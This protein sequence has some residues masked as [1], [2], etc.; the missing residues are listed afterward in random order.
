M[1]WNNNIGKPQWNG[2]SVNTVKSKN[3]VVS[4]ITTDDI[5]AN[6]ISTGYLFAHSL[7]TNNGAISFLSNLVLN[8]GVIAL[9]VT[10]TFLTANAGILYVNGDAVAFPS[11]LSTIADWSQFSAV[12]DVNMSRSSLYNVQSISTNILSTGTLNTRSISTT[13]L[14]SGNIVTNNISSGNIFFDTLNGRAG[15]INTLSGNNMVYSNAILSNVNSITTFTRSLNA[16]TIIASNSITSFA[17][18]SVIVSTGY[19]VADV[20]FFNST[21]NS[22][23]FSYKGIFQSTATGVLIASNISTGFIVGSNALFS[24]LNT[25]N[26][27]TNSISTNSIS[28]LNLSNTNL[29]TKNVVL[30][31]GLL[32]FDWNPAIIYNTN[33]NVI[34]S[35][36]LYRAVRFNLGVSPTSNITNWVANAPYLQYNCAFVSGVGSFICLVNTPGSPTSPQFQF[37]V[38]GQISSNASPTAVWTLLETD[39]VSGITGDDYSFIDVGTGNFNTIN[40]SSIN[41]SGSNTNVTISSINTNN[42]SSGTANINFL[43]TSNIYNSNALQTNSLD[44]ISDSQ[45]NT[46]TTSGVVNTDNILNVN[47]LLALRSDLYGQTNDITLDVPPFTTTPQYLKDILNIREGQFETLNIFGG[48]TGNTI[49]PPYRNNSIVNIG[50]S[51]ISPGIVTIGG[52]NAELTTALT[53]NGI[54]SLNGDTTINGLNTVNG[55]TDL[56]GDLT[57]IGLTTITGDTDITGLTS[58]TGNTDIN[59]ACEVTGFTNLLG[60]LSVEAGIAVAGA[61]TFQ[62]GDI[63]IGSSPG[64][65]VVNNFNLY[66]YYNGTDIQNLTVNGSGDFRQNVNID[67]TLTANILNLNS[68]TTKYAN[69]STLLVSSLVGFRGSFNSLSTNSLSTGVILANRGL[70]NS[71]STNS[72]STGVILADRGLFNSLSTNYISSGIITTQ[73][74]STV[75]ISADV[76]NFKE[77]FGQELNFKRDDGGNAGIA[78]YRDIDGIQEVDS[79][80]FINNTDG[81]TILSASTITLL[82][83]KEINI[84]TLKN[85]NLNTPDGYTYAQ[86][87]STGSLY[88]STINFDVGVGQGLLL[89]ARPEEAVGLLFY[90]NIDGVQEIDT[91]LGLDNENNF[92]LTSFSSITI[93]AVNNLAIATSEQ[94][95]LIAQSNI[96]IGTPHVDILYNANISTINT[97]Q[98]STNAVYSDFLVAYNAVVASSTITRSLVSEFVSTGGLIADRATIVNDL[99]ANNLFTTNLLTFYI[100]NPLP[101][102]S[103][104]GFNDNLNIAGNDIYNTFT[105][106]ASNISTNFIS[107]GSLFVNNSVENSISSLRTSTGALFAG[108][109]SSLQVNTSSITGNRALLDRIVPFRDTGTTTANLYPQSAGSQIGFGFTTAGGGFYGFGTFRSTITQVIQPALDAGAFSNVVRINGFVSTQQI[110][111]SSIF[112]RANVS[113]QLLQSSNIITSNIQTQNITGAGGTLITLGTGLQPSS[114]NISLG[115]RTDGNGGGRFGNVFAYSTFTNT[116]VGMTATGFVGSTVS[117]L[118]TLS[119]Q[120]VMVS[121]INNKLYPY[122][123]TLNIPHSTFSITGNQAGTPILLYSNIQFANQGFHRISQKAILSKN[124][125]GPLQD[126]HG[127]IFYTV[128]AFPSTPSITDGYS[129][130]P[131]VNQDNASTFTTLM[132]EF[133]VSSPTTRSIF[134][135]DATANNYSARL[136]L[137]TLFDTFT[138]DFGNNP[139]RIPSIL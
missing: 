125:G 22:T 84:S 17:I 118:N 134:Y 48:S 5:K 34:V 104:I 28:T 85:I 3:L 93:Q 106:S 41:I 23:I 83:N 8:T 72:L 63:I 52:V 131:L 44:V 105:L 81:F 65:G 11:S 137:G 77:A 109:V 60:G 133:Y 50:T 58:I 103:P 39:A 92:T 115:F 87:A 45:L 96:T 61:M 126:I 91:G 135:Y 88:T 70:F 138:P 132:T 32:A 129:S 122:T 25:N 102:Q 139:T 40:V 37:G 119:T 89:Q 35:P 14:A 90:R 112:A 86:Y 114:S 57:V 26:L 51:L 73:E 108:T 12:A 76:F 30:S 82:A 75:N 21:F 33:D 80:I 71:L 79:G 38:W 120:N 4:S 130:L 117:V 56:N 121:S 16:S 31:S 113:T 9:G 2:N 42:I 55:F 19:I 98:I 54:T 49:L 111:T 15:T 20:G 10:P 99:S 94:M 13:N 124:T 101:F 116:I 7:S 128:G 62:G 43:Y 74:L 29:L 24:N 27:N 1:S 66:N 107:T 36:N 68:T 59:G 47:G 136:Y 100:G 110:F 78:F 97:N 64:G 95:T 6:N 53:V 123:S 67:G 46:L 18:S 69:I 127:N